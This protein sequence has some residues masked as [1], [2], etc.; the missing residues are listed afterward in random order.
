MI[1]FTIERDNPVSDAAIE[2]L[3]L[4]VGR[5]EEAGKSDQVLGLTHGCT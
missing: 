4:A 1:D 5:D 3:R 2:A